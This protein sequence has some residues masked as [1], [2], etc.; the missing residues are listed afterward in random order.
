MRT[1]LLTIIIGA[2]GGG[3]ASIGGLIGDVT[4][5][6]SKQLPN[7]SITV[8][9]AATGFS[10]SKV[11]DSHGGCRIDDLLPGEYTVTAQHSG[12]RKVR[13]SSIAV[14]VDRK[15]R[16][17][18]TMSAGP[19]SDA[20]VVIGNGSPLQTDDA[21]EGYQLSSGIVDALPLSSRNII[22]L[23][24]LGPGAIP[25]QLGGFTHDIINDKQANRGAVAL[26]PPLN[27]PNIGVPGP[28]P[29]FGPVYGKAF[30]AGN[31]RPMQFALRYDF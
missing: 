7:I 15:T 28:Y 3:Q 22:E 29:G 14:D 20:V 2:Y 25:R 6:N 23:V 11:T 9:H 18:F 10:R 13:L 26:N 12:F 27:H 24:T 8:Q 4:D 21:S 19:E 16:V 17:D 30:S 31:P 1:A 5:G